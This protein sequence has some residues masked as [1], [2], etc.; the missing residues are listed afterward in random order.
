MPKGKAPKPTNYEQVATLSTHAPGFNP[1]DPKFTKEER[2]RIR[3]EM[4]ALREQEQ[5]LYRL[6]RGQR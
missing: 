3:R 4:L 5:Q 2:A 1:S 6:C